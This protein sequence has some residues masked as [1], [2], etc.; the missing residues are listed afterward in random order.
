VGE[1]GDWEV[2]RRGGE[3]DGDGESFFNI[4]FVLSSAEIPKQFGTF[5]SLRR[6]SRVKRPG[7]SVRANFAHPSQL[8]L[9]DRNLVFHPRRTLHRPRPIPLRLIFPAFATRASLSSSISTHRD[10][11]D[12]DSGEDSDVESEYAPNPCPTPP[13]TRGTESRTKDPTPPHKTPGKAAKRQGLAGK[14]QNISSQQ[15]YRDKVKAIRFLVRFSLHDSPQAEMWQQERF[16]IAF[17]RI[18]WA[19]VDWCGFQERGSGR[20]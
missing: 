10:E 9:S 16:M 5:P 4:S 17:G 14:A 13:K 20:R 2:K 8:E 3:G 18:R 6:H 15:K 19:R 12:C 1:L 11:S 7:R